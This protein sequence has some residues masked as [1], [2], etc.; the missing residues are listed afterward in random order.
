MVDGDH[1]ARAAVTDAAGAFEVRRPACRNR[2]LPGRTPSTC[3]VVGAT[4]RILA[5]T[6]GAGAGCS[7]ADL[8]DSKPADQ[9]VE[10]SL[11]A[12]LSVTQRHGV[13]HGCVSRM[14]FDLTTKASP[15]QVL[16]AMTDFTPGTLGDPRGPRP[17]FTD[18]TDFVDLGVERLVPDVEPTTGH[19]AHGPSSTTS[20]AAIRSK[21]C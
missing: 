7:F 3:E 9:P 10:E 20:L 2:G 4:A 8:A 5:V 17:R 11:G 1:V 13:P 15:E 18:F 14:R 21:I 16:Q 6:S 19:Q 12:N